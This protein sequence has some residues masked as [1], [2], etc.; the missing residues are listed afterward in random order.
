[1]ATASVEIQK[2][3]LSTGKNIMGSSSSDC[4]LRL[5]KPIRATHFRLINVTVP[6]SGYSFSDSNNKFHY[7]FSNSSSVPGTLQT[8]TFLT[9]KRY[10]I[11]DIVSELSTISNITVSHVNNSFKLT[12]THD[13]TSSSNFLHLPANQKIGLSTDRVIAKNSSITGSNY[14]YL[15]STSC[16]YLA[17]PT[18]YSRSVCSVNVFEEGGGQYSDC[19]ISK[20]P[21]TSANSLGD[22]ASYSQQSTNMMKISNGEI[23]I[24]EIHI[25]LLTDDFKL[26]ETFGLPSHVELDF[27]DN[28]QNEVLNPGR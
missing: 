27:I 17:S 21:F 28:R 22:I 6:N 4:I 10:T 3:F 8:H 2:V 7:S 11:G 12:I 26:Y 5:S 19:V 20:I 18:L 1:M 13:S 23:E 25:R 16:V 9:N 15:A 24:S 14:V